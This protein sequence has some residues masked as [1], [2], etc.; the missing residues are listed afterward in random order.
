MPFLTEELWQ[1]LM[2]WP[3]RNESLSAGEK[4]LILAPWPKAEAEDADA[5][6]D[7]ELVIEIIRQIRN[8]RAEAV[9]A[10]HRVRAPRC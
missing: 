7:F 10:A 3:S 5:E 1:H 4:S 6:R 9:A 8:A 2:G